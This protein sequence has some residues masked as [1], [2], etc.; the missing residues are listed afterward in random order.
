MTVK[1]RIEQKSIEIS[2]KDR[3]NKYL[4]QITAPCSDLTFTNLFMWRKSYNIRWAEVCDTLFITFGH[5]GAPFAACLPIGG[6]LRDA[7]FMLRDLFEEQGMKLRITLYSDGQ[8]RLLERTFPDTFTFTPQRSQFDYVYSVRELTALSGKRYHAKKNH[9][10]KFK[11]MY[12]WEYRHMTPE[13][14]PLC[15]DVFRRWY[16]DK[17]GVIP[18]VEEQ[19]EAVSELLNN[20]EN[21]DITGGCLTADGSIAAFSFGE[22][23][24]SDPSCAVIHLEHADTNFQGSYAAM[25]QQFLEHEWQDFEYVN[26]EED[27]GIE[28]LRKAKLS[29]N[30]A[31][32]VKKYSAVL[33]RPLK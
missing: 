11:S 5:S 10:N 24:H 15:E 13:Y 31:F 30:P 9:L 28:G 2:D 25:N 21:L 12:D 22:P 6:S 7:V 29:Y 18:G 33:K 1:S 20:W 8:M 27:M 3:L 16:K 32:M 23:L 14:R 26:R 17:I 4:S 19:F